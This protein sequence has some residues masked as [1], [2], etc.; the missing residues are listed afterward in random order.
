MRI[1][2]TA[3]GQ[4]QLILDDHCNVPTCIGQN[5]GSTHYDCC[6]S[7]QNYN[8]RQ[9]QYAHALGQFAVE[10][11]PQH[12]ADAVNKSYSTW[13]QHIDYHCTRTF[14]TAPSSHFHVVCWKGIQARYLLAL[15]ASLFCSLTLSYHTSLLDL[16]YMV[17]PDSIDINGNTLTMDYC[18]CHVKLTL[19]ASSTMRCRS[20]QQCEVLHY[21]AITAIHLAQGWGIKSSSSYGQ[22]QIAFHVV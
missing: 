22:K 10:V 13:Q 11:W 8:H 5:Q 19:K 3:H 12:V 16:V 2:L 6:L 9:Y 17:T 20:V 14:S 1:R 21:A 4:T 18:C 7:M 15:D